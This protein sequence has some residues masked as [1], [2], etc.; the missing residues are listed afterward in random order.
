MN[1]TYRLIWSAI[2]EV[3]MAV[4]E[5]VR[6]C[7]ARPGVTVG[8]LAAAVLAAG[9]AAFAVD[10][11]A[12]PTGGRITAGSG[13]INQ[14]GSQMTINQA[15]QQMIANWSTFN[16]GQNAGVRF[17]Q[18]NSAATALNRIQDQN[19]TQILGSLSANGKVFL[20]NPSG[21]IFGRSAR[22]DVGGLV[23]SSLD[24]ADSDFMAGRYRFGN[25]GNAGGILN[26][27]SI[28]ANGGVVALIAPKVQNE[29]AITTK[30]GSTVLAAGNQV[31]VDF[32]GD[33]LVSYTVD[34]GAVD[35]LAENRGADQS[36]RRHGGDDRQGGGQPDHGRGEQQRRDRGKQSD[37]KRGKDSP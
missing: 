23:A 19:P 26:Q 35:A 36:G 10:P 34:Q 13:T 25:P 14:S 37:R 7:G 20:L 28:G 6:D 12:L 5:K 18:P 4:S 32:T 11:G 2:K 17:N 1:K 16:I 30:G 27:G 24:L 21:I 29:G 15:S 31:S 22:V 3:W 9:G 33:G 8:T